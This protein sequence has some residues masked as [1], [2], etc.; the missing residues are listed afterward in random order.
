MELSMFRTV[1]LSGVQYCIN[2]NGVCHTGYPESLLAVSRWIW[3]HPDTA[4]LYDI[5]TSC[6]VYSTRL[7]MMDRK[8]VRNMQNSIPKINLRNQCRQLVLLQGNFTLH[9]PLNGK[10]GGKQLQPF[11]SA[12]NM[13]EVSF[14]ETLPPVYQSQSDIPQK[15]D[16]YDIKCKY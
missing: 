2:S 1:P 3:F 14:S 6:C 9:G 16:A 11:Y 7:L 15:I 13:E 5:Y 10:F 8:P 12:V 4:N